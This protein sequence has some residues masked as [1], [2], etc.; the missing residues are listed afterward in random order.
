MREF[1]LLAVSGRDADGWRARDLDVVGG[2]GGDAGT[3][4][5]GEGAA[6]AAKG[7]AEGDER[8]GGRDLGGDGGGGGGGC[9]G[10]NC[11]WSPRWVAGRSSDGKVLAGGRG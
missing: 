6:G 3:W 9:G 5:G 8:H 10:N 4:R 11:R 1:A 7:A 2:F